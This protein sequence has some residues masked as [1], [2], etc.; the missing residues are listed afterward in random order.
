M[1]ENNSLQFTDIVSTDGSALGNPHGPIGWGWVNQ[2]TGAHDAGGASNGTNQI[3]ELCAILEALRHH[4]SSEHLLIESDSE[5]AINC[6]SVWITNWKKN[7]WTNS[8]KKPVKNS[9]IIQAIDWEMTHRSGTV[10]FKWVKGHAGNKFNEIVDGLAHGY[11]SAVAEGRK[12][13]YMPLEGWDALLNS[14]YHEG[15]D[16]PPDILQKLEEQH[17]DSQSNEFMN[18][19]LF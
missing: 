10:S 14:P 13:G 16:I 3:G 9:A 8:H 19:I 15:L 7:G 17:D 12:T 5:Y 4:H 2:R 11:S 1:T 6:S 18:G